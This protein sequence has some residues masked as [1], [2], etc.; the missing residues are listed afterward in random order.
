MV[1]AGLGD[2]A[3]TGLADYARSNPATDTAN[4]LELAAYAARALARTPAAAASFAYTLDGRR[5]VVRLDP[6]DAFT[7]ELT[8]R[9]AETLSV[10]TLS[11][12]VGAVV[13]ARV[14]VAPASLHPHADLT[15]T[16]AA[17]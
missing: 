14:P 2:P 13:A 10:E 16:R 1:A 4:D 11:G 8:A 7:L 5:T 15:F 6:G 9:Q 12:Q 3:A 17:A